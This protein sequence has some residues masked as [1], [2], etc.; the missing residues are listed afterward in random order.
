MNIL[1]VDDEKYTLIVIKKE[2]EKVFG[3]CVTA[4]NTFDEAIKAVS[5]LGTDNSFS[6]AFL[7]IQIRSKSGVE[8]AKKI[9][10]ISP[11]TKIIFCTAYR[12]FAFEAYQLHAI[13]YLMKPVKEKQIREVLEEMDKGWKKT[14]LNENELIDVHTFGNFEVF[15]NKKPLIFERE[16]SKELL[17]YLIDRNGAAVTTAEIAGILW[18]D[19]AYDNKVKNQVTTIISGLKKAL[20]AVGAD[21]VLVKTWN[22]LSIDTTKVKCDMYDFIKGDAAAINAYF[23]EYMTNYSWAEFTNGYLN[24]RL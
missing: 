2:L 6:Y 22:H 21:E 1:C 18:E 7:D 20:K 12:E 16:K 23:G 14:V 3:E 10:E 4:V 24:E 9:K 17:A 11:Q 15:A 13:G 5:E 8:L 19:R